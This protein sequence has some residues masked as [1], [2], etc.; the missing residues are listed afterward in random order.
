MLAANDPISVCGCDGSSSRGP[1]STNVVDASWFEAAAVSLK[2]SAATLRKCSCGDLLGQWTQV[3]LQLLASA[4]FVVHEA[5]KVYDRFP[6]AARLSTAASACVATAIIDGHSDVPDG[7]RIAWGA[8]AWACAAAGHPHSEVFG[9]PDVRAIPAASRA[10]WNALQ[11]ACGLSDGSVRSILMDPFPLVACPGWLS[12]ETIDL[13]LRAADG[14]NLWEPS[15]LAAPLPGSAPPQRTSESALLRK[16][17]LKAECAEAVE[18]LHQRAASLVGL[19]TSHAEP[20]QLVRYRIGQQYLPHMD[21]G[22]VN[23][24]SLWIAGQRVATVLV[25][26]ND[27]PPG[28]QGGSTRFTRVGSCLDGLRVEPSGGMAVAWPNVSFDGAPLFETEHEAEMLKAD[29]ATWKQVAEV[30]GP[31]PKK[32]ALNIWIRDR[33]LPWDC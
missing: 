23:D 18:L 21:W 22:S 30:N 10:V 7:E 29:P 5:L 24:A 25:Y 17:A 11:N 12:Q 26:L 19:P 13:L 8:L 3:R 15:P 14:E 31:A 9:Q 1:L 2:S 27:L 16:G 32:L 33:Q 28:V 4:T 6:D 20:P